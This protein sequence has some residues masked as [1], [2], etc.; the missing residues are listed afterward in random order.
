MNTDERR[1]K[2]LFLVQNLRPFLDWYP[3]TAPTIPISIP[4]CGI[5]DPTVQVFFT[6]KVR[7]GLGERDVALVEGSPDVRGERDGREVDQLLEFKI[8][9]ILSP[10]GQGHVRDRRWQRTSKDW[11]YQFLTFWIDGM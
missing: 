4:I 1:Q 11:A 10:V 6:R 7:S 9:L 8:M 5:T 2:S 3:E